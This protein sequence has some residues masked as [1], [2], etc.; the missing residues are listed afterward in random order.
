MTNWT[1]NGALLSFTA[2]NTP[3]TSVQL[4]ESSNVQ[5]IDVKIDNTSGTVDCIVGWG[6]NDAQ[7]KYNAAA[8]SDVTN[9]VWIMHGTIQI[10][11]M[12]S[13]AYVTGYTA[14]STAVVKVQAGT[15]S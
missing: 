3:P 2:A 10:V 4:T 1:P 11:C 8:T 9:C 13:N 14:S 7:A 12:P 5:A 15:G 6:Q